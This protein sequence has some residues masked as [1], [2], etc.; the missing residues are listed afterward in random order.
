MWLWRRVAARPASDVTLATEAFVALAAARAALALFDL[1]RMHSILNRL[2]RGG[3][4]ARPP[5]VNSGSLVWALEAA[6]RVFP[7]RT[8]CL[9][10]ALAAEAL[11]RRHGH[12]P[13]LC[14]GAKLTNGKLEAHAWIE[15]ADQVLVGGPAE[16]VGQYTR[17]TGLSSVTR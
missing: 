2:R 15:E 8:T 9:V 14:I 11:F 16:V 17:F 4:D 6:R 12:E 1:R 10:E 7:L 3:L 13:V 5:R